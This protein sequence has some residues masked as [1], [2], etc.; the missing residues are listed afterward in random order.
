[1]EQHV[2]LDTCRFKGNFKLRYCKNQ[3]LG[4]GAGFEMAAYCTKQTEHPDDVHRNMRCKECP[5]FE[6]YEYT[7]ET[8]DSNCGELK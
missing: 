3:K 2:R 6:A 1:M 8:T 5:D 7:M 4:T